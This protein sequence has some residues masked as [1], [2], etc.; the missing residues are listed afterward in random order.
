M[1]KEW[2]DVS[3]SKSAF[4][5]P[6]KGFWL[7]LGFRESRLHLDWANQAKGRQ[8]EET[9]RSKMH[10]HNI[11]EDFLFSQPTSNFFKCIFQLQLTYNVILVSGVWG[12]LIRL[13]SYS[14]GGSW[15]ETGL[16]GLED[17]S[18]EHTCT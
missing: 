15:E 2:L 10:E 5:P 16:G 11:F 13:V 14:I 3:K 6:N 18:Q 12:I 9:K 8:A 17:I 4:R 1:P 7:K